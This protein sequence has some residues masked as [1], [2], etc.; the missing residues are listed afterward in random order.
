MMENVKDL[1]QAKEIAEHV[2][3]MLTSQMQMPDFNV[4]G[5]VPVKVAARVLGKDACYVQAGIEAGWLPIGV[6]RPAEEGRSRRNFYISP[7]LFWE[8]TGYVWKGEKT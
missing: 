8:L 4:D 7:K 5:G 6:V 2:C 3:R 1:T